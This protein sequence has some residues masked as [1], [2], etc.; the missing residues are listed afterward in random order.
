MPFQSTPGPVSKDENTMKMKIKPVTAAGFFLAI[1]GYLLVSA[2]QHFSPLNE[3]F[4]EPVLTLV[5]LGL[6]WLV[7][8]L[9]VVIVKFGEKKPLG[10]IGFQSISVKEALLAVG[11]GIVLSLAVPVL[12]LLASQLLPATGSDI[13]QVTATTAWWLLLLS[14]LTAGVT[15]EVIFRGYLIERVTVISGKTALAVIVSVIAF[16]LPHIFSWNLAH[17]VGVVLP[18]GILLGL[19][20]LWKRNL[21]FNI[22]VHIVIDVPLVVMALLSA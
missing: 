21:V 19:L 12:T 13:E 18:L 10:S 9:L 4:P 3:I 16:V 1:F 14:I 7:T 22:I 15:E 20:Y 2:I 5:G 8:V 6:V 17:V 11:L